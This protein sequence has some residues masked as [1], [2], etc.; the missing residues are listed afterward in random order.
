[1]YRIMLQI[2]IADSANKISTTLQCL[3]ETSN[4]ARQLYLKKQ[5]YALKMKE[6]ESV[7]DLDSGCVKSIDWP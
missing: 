7:H 6:E 5:L 3:Y 1:M 2:I 4:H